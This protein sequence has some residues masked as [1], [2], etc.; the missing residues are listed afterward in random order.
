[1]NY[2]DNNTNHY[3]DNSYKDQKLIE[4]FMDKEDYFNIELFDKNNI[5][6]N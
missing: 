4:K 6:W 3:F 1:M 2:D 5:E